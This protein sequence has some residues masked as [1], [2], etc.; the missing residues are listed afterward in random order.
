MN[1]LKKT[2]KSAKIRAAFLV[3]VN[4]IMED[5][6]GNI[7]DCI[8]Y[9]FDCMCNFGKFFKE[10]AELDYYFYVLQFDNGDHID[11]FGISG[12]GD[13]R[14]GSWRRD[15]KCSIFCDS[16]KDSGNCCDGQRYR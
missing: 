9:F 11:S 5:Q 8:I 15:Y 4:Q 13:H 2:V 7:S 10:S 12:F 3:I 14:G 1:S 6:N 16:Q